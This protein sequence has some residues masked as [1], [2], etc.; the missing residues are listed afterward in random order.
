MSTPPKWQINFREYLD[1][2][3]LTDGKFRDMLRLPMIEGIQEVLPLKEIKEAE[4]VVPMPQQMLRFILRNIRT[5]DGRQR[6]FEKATFELQKMGIRPLHIG[7]KFAYRENYVGLLENLSDIF[8]KNHAI[9][10]GILELGAFLVFGEDSQGKRGLAFYLPPIIEMH[11]GVPVIMDGIH[12]DF[13]AL[14]MG[15]TI[16]AIV[17]SNVSAPFP[18]E[19]H[20][21]DDLRVINAADKPKDLNERY[22]ELHKELFRDLKYFGIDG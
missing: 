7:Q 15:A 22:F 3:E 20:S 16:F 13:I 19:P 4:S 21:W 11:N 2:L 9:N 14:Q 1:R 10:S 12:R 6:P 8:R 5:L 18:C 17:V